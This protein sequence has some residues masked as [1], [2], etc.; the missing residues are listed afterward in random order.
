M[1]RFQT[2][3]SYLL[4]VLN[5]LLLFLLIFQEKVVIPSWMQPIGRLHPLML[6]LPIGFLIVVGLLWVFQQEF[7]GESFSKVLGFVLS[8]TAFTATLAALMG[9]FLSREEGY[10]DSLLDWHKYTGIALSFLL[11]GLNILY[12]Q[13]KKQKTFFNATLAV[14]ILILTIT[15]HLGASLTHGED[16]LFLSKNS[17]VALIINEDTPVFEAV[18]QPIFKAK[19]VQCHNEQKT[20]GELLMTT[21]S[22]LVKG[23]KNGPIW[24]AGDAFNSHFLQR[25]NLPLEDKKH[26]PPKGKAQLTPQEIGILTAWVQ[27]GADVKKPIKALASGDPIQKWIESKNKQQHTTAR[28]YDFEAAST[29]TIEKLNTPF[30]TIFPLAYNSP[31]LQADFFVRQAYKPE[32]LGELSEIKT[33]LVAL[34]LSNMPIKDEDLN[35][36]A[37]FEHLEKLI[38]N[39][40]NITGNSLSALSKLSALK[41]LS[42][43]G[44]KITKTSLQSLRKFPQ[45]REVFVWNTSVSQP[46]IADLQKQNKEIHFELGYLPKASEILKINPPILVNEKFVLDPQTP[47]SFRH[48][49]KGVTIRY[50]LDGTIPD[51]LS[52]PIYES[53]LFL[54]DYTLVKA[55]ATKA[56]WYASDVVQYAFFKATYRPDSVTL[57]SEPNSQYK[58]EGAQTLIDRNKGEASDFKNKAWLGYR[59]NPLEAVFTFTKPIPLK[60]VT[61]STGINIQGYIF[62]PASIEI[63]GG[64]DKKSLRLIQRIIPDQPKENQ[65]TRIEAYQSK[66]TGVNYTM[67]KVIVRPV[68]KLPI[69]HQGKGQP[70]W[71][72]VDEVFF[73]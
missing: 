36:I 18:I 62:P 52:A 55:R 40:T 24:V 33:Q 38:L 54:S 48:P 29:S 15:G 4:L 12:Q 34:N 63:W 22:G 32:Q 57:L 2:A 6:H 30:R 5:V 73:N 69:W 42:L 53:P 23:G 17:E 56:Q 11:Y 67:L 43:S 16:Y 45:L 37:Q 49:L 41:S 20:K 61:I 71:T 3:I 8:F 72:F 50:T 64:S 59:E 35:T 28:T 46:D 51:S 9:F 25:A 13:T 26:M 19:C 21:L 58:G 1:P 66:I 68:S 31:A 10:I 14:S 47:I 65:A 44:T 7:Q 39:N 60:N 27:S 70:A